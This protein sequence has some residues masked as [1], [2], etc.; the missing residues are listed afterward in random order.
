MQTNQFRRTS[1]VLLLVVSLGYG[2][3]GK[4]GGGSGETGVRRIERP[5]VRRRRPR[6]HRRRWFCHRI[7]REERIGYRWFAGHRRR[8][9]ERAPPAPAVRP[10]TGA[11]GTGGHRIRWNT[12]TGTGGSSTTGAGGRSTYDHHA[13]RRQHR[14]CGRRD[15]QADDLHAC[16]RGPHLPQDQGP[17]RGHALQRRRGEHRRDD[18]PGRSATADHHLGDERDVS[19]N[20]R[21]E[22]APVL[23][24]PVSAGRVHADA[25]LQASAAGERRVR[26]RAARHRRRR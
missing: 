15:R 10:P 6:Q 13:R 8:R 20:V 26:L 24:Q 11:G 16:P 17:A 18:G 9:L 19:A 14:R 2:C 4:I 21:G 3:T 1:F 12:G 22:D 5:G 25:G 7:G 23:P